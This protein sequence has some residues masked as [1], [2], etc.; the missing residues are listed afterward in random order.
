[1]EAQGIKKKKKKSFYTSARA[2]CSIAYICDYLDH[3][4]LHC[5]SCQ[6][7]QNFS[8][9]L[10]HNVRAHTQEDLDW[11]LDDYFFVHLLSQNCD[12]QVRIFLSTC[13][14]INFPV[15]ADKTIWSTQTIGL[16]L[17]TLLQ[18]VTI[19][20]DKRLKAL[21]AIDRVLR[22][23]KVKVRELQSLTGQLN[24]LSKAVVPGRA[25]TR[26]MYAKYNNLKQHHHLRVD[27]ELRLDCAMWERFLTNPLNVSRPFQDF[28]ES[29]ISEIRHLTS[30]ASLNHKLGFGGVF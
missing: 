11:Y 16:L 1:M 4:F 7:F 21:D 13:D 28:S 15:S 17:N 8:D 6:I 24:F 2:S 30:D 3:W 10:A 23:R 25:F 22:A 9:S 20:E 19:P 5:R 29:T 14:Q 26:H 18:V 27:Q 12:W